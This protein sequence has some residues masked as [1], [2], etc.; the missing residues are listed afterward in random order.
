MFQWLLEEAAIRA[1]SEGCSFM[2]RIGGEKMVEDECGHRRSLSGAIKRRS[3]NKSF[4]PASSTYSSSNSSSF[5]N[6]LYGP[7][8]LK[9][10]SNVNSENEYSIQ[11][12]IAYCTKS[13]QQVCGRKSVSDVEFYLLTESKLDVECGK[14]ER[15]GIYRG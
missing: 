2:R 8:M 11:G 12:A 1:N 3:L 4:S 6:G 15:P 14:Q 10:S 9:R 5:S 13:Q 7:L